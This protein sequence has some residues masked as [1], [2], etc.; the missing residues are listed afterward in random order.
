M[1][2]CVSIH[3]TNAYFILS[4]SHKYFY[5]P[6]IFILLHVWSLMYSLIEILF[7]PGITF[8]IHACMYMIVCTYI[9]SCSSA[10]G[11]PCMHACIHLPTS[12]HPYINILV[13]MSTYMHIYL[14][15]L[16][17]AHT[18]IYACTYLYNHACLPIYI[19]R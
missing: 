2:T 11:N 14:Y 1:H 16:K 8:Y 19:L 3:N 13:C 9:H 7:F 18:Y 10:Y 17:H 4:D 12:I 5:L 15:R 6:D